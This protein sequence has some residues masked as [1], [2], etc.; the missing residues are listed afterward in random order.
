MM[1]KLGMKVNQLACERVVFVLADKEIV[2][3]DPTVTLI[4]VQGERMY[5]VTGREVEKPR[6]EQVILEFS[7]EDVKLVAEQAG[8]SM[9][10]A[11][12]ALKETGGDLAQAII[13]LQ[14]RKGST[15]V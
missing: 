3:E 12:N 4:E 6:E 7:E 2:I 14:T 1:R 10:E 8:V 13:L 15:N 11:R 9:D 5:Q